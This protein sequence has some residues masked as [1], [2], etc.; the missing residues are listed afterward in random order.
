[1][2][3]T[4]QQLLD[5]GYQ[6]QTDGSYARPEKQ[7]KTPSRA[8]SAP[9]NGNPESINT[10]KTPQLEPTPRPPSLVPRQ[11]QG[12]DRQRFLVRTTSVRNRLLD[13]DNL[14]EKYHVDLCRYAGI[15]PGDEAGTTKIETTQRKAHKGEEEHTLI[16]VLTFND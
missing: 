11:T 8:V 9:R 13:E 10:R 15:I 2:P 4:Q 3:F 6:L 7:I 12:S 5:L 14:C 1:M 16:E